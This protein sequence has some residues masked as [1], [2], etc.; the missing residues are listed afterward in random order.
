MIL[1]IA[2]YL[3]EVHRLGLHA[4][5]IVHGWSIGP[6]RPT[7]HK[8][9]ERSPLMLVYGGTPIDAGDWDVTAAAFRDSRPDCHVRQFHL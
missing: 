1:S 3:E 4:L 6:S 2:A 9:L 7:V 8:V 5:R